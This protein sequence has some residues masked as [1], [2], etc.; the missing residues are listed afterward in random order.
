MVGDGDTLAQRTSPGALPGN[1]ARVSGMSGYLQRMIGH[2]KAPV[3]G[4]R[5]LVGSVYAAAARSSGLHAAHEEIAAPSPAR[6][7]A[8]SEQAV[9]RDE[10]RVFA[11]R[12][13]HL[14]ETNRREEPMRG[15]TDAPFAQ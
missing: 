7:E 3:S 1:G 4:M 6:Y 13:F 9:V 15:E 8:Q 10:H 14:A 11:P 12:D 2:V 5:P